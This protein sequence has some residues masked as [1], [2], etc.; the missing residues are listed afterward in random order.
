MTTIYPHTGLHAQLDAFCTALPMKLK[1]ERIQRKL[2]L[3]QA[4]DQIGISRSS[5]VRAEAGYDP[6]L[7][8]LL[9]IMRWLDEN[10]R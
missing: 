2:S 1:Y 9:A 5:L 3:Q 10:P 8:T 7:Y 6:R 4:A